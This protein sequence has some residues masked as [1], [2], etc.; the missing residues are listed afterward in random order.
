MAPVHIGSGERLS[1]MEFQIKKDGQQN[2]LSVF[3]LDA[4]LRWIG[5]QPNAERFASLLTGL[6]EN[7]KNGGLLKFIADYKVP[8][9][10]V[11]SYAIQLAEGVAAHE[12]REVLTFIK[13]A[14]NRVYLPGSSLKGAFRSALLRGALIQNGSLRVS[15]ERAVLDG[16][17]ENRTNSNLIEAQVF[18]KPDIKPSRWSN[19]DL[20]RMI[21]IRDSLP[22]EAQEALRLYAVRILSVGN[23]NTL[24]WK[25]NPNGKGFTTL[26]VEM[27]QAGF[28]LTLPVVWQGYLLSELAGEIKQPDRESIFVFWNAYL[29]QVSMNLLQQERDFYQRYAK[30]DLEQWFEKRINQLQKSEENVCLLPLGW[31]SGYDAKTVTDLFSENTFQTVVHAFVKS[32]EKRHAFR[33]IQGLGRPGNNPL[34]KW[35]GAADS[36]KSRKVIYKTDTEAQPLG[37][38]A[39]R[40]DPADEETNDWMQAE[41]RRLN[42]YLPAAPAISRPVEKTQSDAS[43]TVGEAATRGMPLSS[44]SQAAPQPKPA[45][46]LISRFTD[47]PTVGDIFEGIYVDEDAGEVLYEIPGLEFDAQAYAVVLRKEFPSF[48]KK[49]LRCRL[50]VKDVIRQAQN[51]YKII[52]DPDW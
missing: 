20:N 40:L 4:L 26:F 35:L 51:Y 50:T 13:T 32:G 1:N 6:L 34:A 22:F 17:Q 38:V 18:V 36:P 42:R 21:I 5:L 9:S 23:Q 41:R 47:I 19:Y 49:L 24:H 27:L 12:V 46:R 16:V 25:Q 37:W 52:C 44:V 43:S 28:S 39:I 48:P 11:E 8:L 3:N 45:A 30:K 7:P 31:G 2:Y 10:S 33:N 14:G 29:R 15:A